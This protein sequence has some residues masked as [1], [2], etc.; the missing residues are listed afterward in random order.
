VNG[1]RS[2]LDRV[3]PSLI[4]I[5]ESEAAR[6]VCGFVLEGS[7]AAS[8]EI[9]ALRNVAGDPARAFR[10]DPGDVLA[11]L[12][13]VEQERCG[14]AALYHSHPSGGAALSARDLAD[15]T[16]EG[17]PLLPGVEL[18]VI[19]IERGKVVEVRAYRFTDGGYAEVSRRRAPFTL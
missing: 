15:L 8:P 14:L 11:V 5:A 7:G 18:W 19:G 4:A 17:G 9:V 12:R 2:V 13:R 16:M 10:M 6:E 1:T 3:L